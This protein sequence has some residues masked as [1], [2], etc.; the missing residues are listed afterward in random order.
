M[1]NEDDKLRERSGHIVSDDKLVSFLYILLRD[2]LP[3][4]D[5]EEIVREHTSNNEMLFTNG[6]LAEY[7]KDIAGRLKREG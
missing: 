4:A 7:A 3:S 2:H 5:V 6:W 1:R